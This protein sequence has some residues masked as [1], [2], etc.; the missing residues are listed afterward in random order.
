MAERPTPGA[1]PA[2]SDAL[3][4]GRRS[5]DQVGMDRSDEMA[6]RE[7]LR[8]ALRS[9]TGAD[10]WTA[11]A[12]VGSEAVERGGRLSIVPQHLHPWCEVPEGP[13]ELR[14]YAVYQLTLI[15]GYLRLAPGAEDRIDTGHFALRAW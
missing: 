15:V 10:P 8:A 3:D 4:M 12:F 6:M 2:A 14:P 9:V 13:V 1:V 5:A 7:R 11:V